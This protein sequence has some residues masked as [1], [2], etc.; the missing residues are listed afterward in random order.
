MKR[1]DVG[2]GLEFINLQNPEI[3]FSAME[4]KQRVVIGTDLSTCDP[5]GNGFIE[6]S[7]EG[8]AI[9]VTALSAESDNATAK[10]VHDH[11]YPV[12]LKNDQL[13]SK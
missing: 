2:H 4:F 12:T 9:D 5:T 1:W 13:A 8:G 6:H 10:L 11:K 7:G 3:R